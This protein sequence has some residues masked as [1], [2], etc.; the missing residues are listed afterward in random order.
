MPDLIRKLFFW[1]FVAFLIFFMA[2]RPE[3]AANMF[4]GIGS[5]LMA[6]MQ[7]FGDFFTRLVS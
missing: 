6:I 2:F 3:A 4:R 1:G 5:A 7:G